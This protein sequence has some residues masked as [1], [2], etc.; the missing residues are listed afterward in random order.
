M[1][2]VKITKLQEDDLN[3]FFDNYDCYVKETLI[4]YIVCN[5]IDGKTDY[6]HLF[7][8]GKLEIVNIILNGYELKKEPHEVVD[9]YVEILGRELNE[10]LNN[11]NSLSTHISHIRGKID[12]AKEL[13]KRLDIK[14]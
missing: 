10:S 1:N 11:K 12:G 3:D 2:I 13:A 7:E 9:D 14:K 8:L 6:P 5:E 4:K